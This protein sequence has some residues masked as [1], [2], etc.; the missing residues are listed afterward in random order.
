MNVHV[1]VAIRACMCTH[2]G[3]VFICVCVCVCVCKRMCVCVCVHECVEEVPQQVLL[4]LLPNCI[5]VRDF[6]VRQQYQ[7]GFILL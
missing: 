7:F 2:Y 3:C 6:A 4:M 1:C 5:W